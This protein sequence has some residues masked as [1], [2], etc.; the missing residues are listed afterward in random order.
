MRPFEFR[1]TGVL[2]AC[3]AFVLLG[4]GCAGASAQP[5]ADGPGDIRAGALSPDDNPYDYFGGLRYDTAIPSPESVLGYRIGQRF[6]RHADVMDYLREVADASDRV[7]MRQYGETHEGRSLHYLVVSAPEN[8]ARLDEIRDRNLELMDPRSADSQR[9]QDTIENNPA[10]AWFSY[11]VHGNEASSSETAMQIAYTMAAGTNDEVQDI[12]DKVVLVIEPMINPDGRDRYVN[13]YNGVVG[14]EKNPNPDAAEHDE[15]WP[16][17]RTNHYYFD[18]NR[19]WL[20]L[21]HPESQQRLDVYTQFRP[22]LH[23]DY[24]EQ[25]Y[26]SP[27]F[28]GAGDD[29]YNANIPQE[30]RDWIEMYGAANAEVFDREGLVYST[31][32]RFDYLYPGYGKVLP[33]YHGAV[34]MLTEK[35]GHG[36]AGLAIEVSDQYTLRLTD[37]ARHHFLTSMSYLET[38]AANRRGQLERFHRFFEE[39]L[40][41][42]MYGPR[43]FV[44]SADNDPDA[45]AKVWN[46][47]DTHGVEI[48]ETQGAATMT[49]LRAYRS[50]QAAGP[51]TLP[52]G[53]WII[54]ADQPM[55]RLARALFERETEVSDIDTYD[56]T[57][58]SLPIM[59]GLNAWY[60]QRPVEAD[61]APLNRWTR[62]SA[63]HTGDGDV[64]IVIDA[65]QRAFP[66]AVG[67][68]MEHE[69][70]CRF[71]GETFEIE[72]RRFGNGSLIVHTVR[73]PQ[74]DLDAFLD[75]LASRGLSA[76]RAGTGMSSVGWV[77]GANHNGL[78][79]LPKVLLLRDSPTSAYSYGQHWHLLDIESPLPYT[80]VNVDALAGVDLEEYNVIVVPE[81]WGNLSDALGER[82]VEEIESWVRE[83]GVVVASGG[84][85][86]WASRTLLELEPEPEQE[87]ADEEPTPNELTWEERRQRSVR[88]RIPGAMLSASV[89]MTHPLSAGVRDWL[90]VIKR[91]DDPLP[92]AENGY[93]VARFDAEPRIG[94]A[95]SEANQDRLGGTPF[96]THHSMGRGAVICFSDDITFRGFNHAAMRLLLNAIAFGPSL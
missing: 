32:E 83:G 23:I 80:P 14:V 8:L 51:V 85:S 20:W 15:P 67:L 40:T 79:E 57:G 44:I 42:E 7:I 71:A 19:D 96:V 55:G 68:A 66:E 46:I 52:A 92:V 21:V 3:I 72:G 33:V 6:T 86:W 2:T 77:L 58:W 87:Q 94:G 35:G 13:W 37:R 78:F 76:H 25:G 22:Q 4:P 93:V 9:V 38:T 29:P 84:S 30:T 1:P 62:P 74:R 50:G 60:A 54:R 64:A 11:N 18:L 26:L 28:F 31:K 81:A 34:G 59:F 41:S 49:G 48:D 16:G 89:D 70:F 91:R 45:L 12:L 90:G 65:D 17:G 63:R 69:L 36:R 53:S 5:G 39:S 73:N 24:H 61:T 95:I 82:V 47:C 88:D 56:I 27:Y 10:I 43:A 75:D